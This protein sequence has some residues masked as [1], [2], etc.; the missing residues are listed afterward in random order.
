MVYLTSRGKV[1]VW[2][3]KRKMRSMKDFLK[4]TYAN[5]SASSVHIQKAKKILM[6]LPNLKKV[7]NVGSNPPPPFYNTPYPKPPKLNLSKVFT[8]M[9]IP[10]TSQLELFGPMPTSA[11][12]K[13]MA[14]SMMIEDG[15][16]P[17][18]PNEPFQQ[19]LDRMTPQSRRASMRRF[20]KAWRIAA[21]Y[22]G[23][24]PEERSRLSAKDKRQL[25]Y[26]HYINK[27]KQ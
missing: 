16:I 26:R 1:M 24:G 10:N 15:L 21:K 23:M 8:T 4:D 27:A 7:P 5:L 12:N 11:H 13:T 25:V 3:Q 20:R 2:A 6:T 18:M 14:R 9:P 19:A 22:K 17:C